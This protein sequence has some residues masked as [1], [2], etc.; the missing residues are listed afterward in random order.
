MTQRILV[1]TGVWY[2]MFVRRDQHA[3]EIQN[4]VEFLEAPYEVVIPW[5]TV[6]ETLKSGFVKHAKALDLFERFLKN[7]HV[8]FLNAEQYLT[9]AF[10]LS[11]DLSLRRGRPMSMVDCLLR[12]LIDDVD[13]RIDGLLTFNARDFADIC[14]K[15]NVSIL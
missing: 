9:D 10:D 12:L 5:P 4:K 11:F 3:A 1:D 15:R 7:P 8:R 13:V 6:Y 2:A 14:L